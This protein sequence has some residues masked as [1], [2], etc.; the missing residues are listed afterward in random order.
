MP[1]DANDEHL[2]RHQLVQRLQLPGVHVMPQRNA[3]H[4]VSKL[5]DVADE[6]ADAQRSKWVLQIR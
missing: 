6:H 2:R 1:S 3:L 4:R 5:H